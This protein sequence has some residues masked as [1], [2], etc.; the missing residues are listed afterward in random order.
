MTFLSVKVQQQKLTFSGSSDALPER[1]V[2]DQI[3]NQQADDQLPFYS[4][5]IVNA[6]A[7][8]ELQNVTA[9]NRRIY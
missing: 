2:T 5:W 7:F 9:E 4:S 6:L 3:D 1:K 8:I